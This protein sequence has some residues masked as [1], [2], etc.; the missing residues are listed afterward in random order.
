MMIRLVLLLCAL[1]FIPTSHA[2][3][4]IHVSWDGI[5]DAEFYELQTSEDSAFKQKESRVLKTPTAVVEL[6]APPPH[7]RIRGIYAGRT[8]S[9][10]RSLRLKTWA[11][12]RLD[13]SLRAHPDEEITWPA[14]DGAAGLIYRVRVV[15]DTG[16]QVHDSLVKAPRFRLPKL[17]G[18][19]YRIWVEAVGQPREGTLHIEGS[20]ATISSLEIK[21]ALPA[22]PGNE[23][24]LHVLTDRF[25]EGFHWSSTLSQQGRTDL[26]EKVWLNSVDGIQAGFTLP[27]VLKDEVNSPRVGGNPFPSL[28]LG[29]RL[30]G[31]SKEHVGAIA[32]LHTSGDTSATLSDFP[33]SLLA[34]VVGRRAYREWTLDGELSAGWMTG[35]A[36][37]ALLRVQGVGSYVM[38]ESLWLR[39]GLALIRNAA[40]G[41]AAARAEARSGVNSAD[42]ASAGGS[43]L[44]ASVFQAGAAYRLTSALILEGWTGVLLGGLPPSAYWTEWSGDSRVFLRASLKV[45][46]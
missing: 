39:G 21:P 6:S 2:G 33:K 24:S 13:P 37:G 10:W 8:A 23:V 32:T 44:W 40:A 11:A 43:G 42:A 3:I 17:S 41:P 28:F 34:S 5:P 14:S 46:L 18:G 30:L 15:A 7:S 1:A 9:P 26:E 25:S 31:N 27:I 35:S 12:P 22:E 45:R 38:S 29:S 16:Y 36:H 20:A 19:E 4:E